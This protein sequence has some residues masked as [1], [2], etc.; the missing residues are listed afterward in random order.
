MSEVPQLPCSGVAGGPEAKAHLPCANTASTLRK[1]QFMNWKVE[2]LLCEAHAELW[3]LI[4]E[5]PAMV[6]RVYYK[7]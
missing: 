3:D 2:V 5:T 1:L 7:P 6:K 4:D